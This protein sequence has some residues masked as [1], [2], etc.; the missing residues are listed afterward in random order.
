MTTAAAQGSTQAASRHGRAR[1]AAAVRARR[2]LG[3]V[4]AAVTCSALVLSILSV[5]AFLYLLFISPLEESRAQ[6]RLYT[7]FRE[8]LGAITA[9][10]G[11]VIAPGAPVALIHIPAIGLGDTVVVEGTSSG[12]LRSGPGHLRDSPLP[13]QIGVSVLYGRG[14]TFGGPFKSIPALQPGNTIT[15]T[16]GQGSFVYQVT[17]VRV[18]GDPLPAPVGAGRSGLMLVTVQSSGWR[19]GWSPGQIVYVDA[20]LLGEAVPAP[21]GHVGAVPKVET[22]MQAD[23]GTLVTLVLWLQLLAITACAVVWA[24]F[25]WGGW[26]MWLV[27]AP[28]LL[29]VLWGA[30]SNAAALLPNLL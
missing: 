16:T 3:H 7:T 2:P 26:Q 25:R 15:A 1:P 23:T 24:Y 22:P 19:S 14:A 21:P 8:Q 11:G 18:A 17:D 28:A 27:G 13:G 6:Q 29:G 5:W 10:I 12:D 20:A 4:T 9:P 30:T